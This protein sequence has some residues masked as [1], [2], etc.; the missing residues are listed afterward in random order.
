MTRLSFI[1]CLLLPFA[2]VAQPAPAPPIEEQLIALE[3]L[4][5]QIDE[6]LLKYAADSAKLDADIAAAQKRRDD[7]KN[8]PTPAPK[9]VPKSTVKHLTFV[10]PTT[11]TASV[12]ND[13]GLR[14][15]LKERGIAV[16]VIPA[17]EALPAGFTK[18]VAD[19]GGVPCFVLQ[20][21]LGKAAGHGK[22]VDAAGVKAA[23]ELVDKEK[24]K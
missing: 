12:V 21:E 1:L 14:L 2:A 4:G 7:L 10:G 13:A 19:A 15:W 8:R 18:A 20:N 23:V 3:K 6:L 11:D 16:H 17:G 5:K 9:P 22:L 24:P